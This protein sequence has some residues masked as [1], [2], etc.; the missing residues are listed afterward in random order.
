MV[1]VRRLHG[2]EV[3]RLFGCVCSEEVD[4]RVKLFLVRPV[5]I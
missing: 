2:L 3:S 5:S 4:S 1:L